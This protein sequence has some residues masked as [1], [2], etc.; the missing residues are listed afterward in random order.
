VSAILAKLKAAQQQRATAIEEQA[1]QHECAMQ[2][3]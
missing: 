1:Q 3:P 2:L